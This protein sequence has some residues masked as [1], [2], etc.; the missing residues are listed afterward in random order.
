VKSVT[1]FHFTK[2]NFKQY[3]LTSHINVAGITISI[4]FSAQNVQF[5]SMEALSRLRRSLIM[6]YHYYA[7][8]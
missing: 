5:T 1:S 6:E 3:F 2:Q 4:P 8:T 7:C